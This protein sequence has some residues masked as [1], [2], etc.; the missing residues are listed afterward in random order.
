MTDGFIG[1]ISVFF[2]FLALV[3]ATMFFWKDRKLA[4]FAFLVVFIVS[5]SAV[6]KRKVVFSS[7]VVGLT[8][9]RYDK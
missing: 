1:L 2:S 3:C 8:V 4:G 6:L 7:S 5:F 9:E